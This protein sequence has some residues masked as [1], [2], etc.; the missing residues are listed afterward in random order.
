M[1][2]IKESELL[3]SLNAP[4]EE[5]TEY[6]KSIPK[7]N[8]IQYLNYLHQ[9]GFVKKYDEFKKVVIKNILEL[10]YT[11][12]ELE[13]I[14]FLIKE[15]IATTSILKFLLFNEEIDLKLNNFGY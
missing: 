8:D 2:P 13:K 7:E 1:E 9:F 15:D 11:K 6:L 10:K 5:I 3:S 4:E 14:N 12:E